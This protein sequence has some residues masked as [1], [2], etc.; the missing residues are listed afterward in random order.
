MSTTFLTRIQSST[1]KWYPIIKYAFVVIVFALIAFFYFYPAITDGREL[2]QPDVAGVS[3]NGS[4]VKEFEKIHP[5]ST[6]Y[7]TNSLFGG[8][9]MYQIAPSYPSVKIVDAMQDIYTLRGPLHLLGGYSWLLF[10]LMIGFF[11][12]LKSLKVSD[13]LSFFG[14]LFW[15]FSSYYLILIA[16]GHIWKLMV[17]AYIPPTIAGMVLIYRQKYLWGGITLTFFVALQLLANHLQM[18]YY[19]LFVMLSFFIVWLVQA[20]RLHQYKE[21][22]I[23]TFVALLSGIVG[24]AINSTNLYHTYQYSKQTMRGGSELSLSPE[25]SANSE[26]NTEG[27]SKGYITQW[28]YGVGETLS[29]LVPNIRGGAS[30]P[31]SNHSDILLNSNPQMAQ[32]VSQFSS[33]WG[34]QPF[35]AGPVYVGVFIFML[36]IMACF[37]VR[38]PIKWALLAMTLFSILLSWGK[39]FMPLTDFFIDYIPLYD[40]FRSVSSIL[41][42]A[43]FT[44]PTLAILGILELIKKPDVLKGNWIV[45]ICAFG[46]PSLL[47]VLMATVPSLFGTFLTEQ[48]AQFFGKNIIQ[49]QG[50]EL[51]RSSLI[52]ARQTLLVNDAKVALLII[53]FSLLALFLY[54]YNRISTMFFVVWIGIVSFVDLWHIDKRYLHDSMFVEP[55]QIASKTSIPSDIDKQIMSLAKP[56]DRVLNLTVDPFND[57]STSRWHLS[58][59]GYHAAKLQRYQ[60]LIDHQLSKRLNPQVLNMLNTRFIIVRDETT[61]KQKFEI[62]NDVYGPAWFVKKVDFV[63][64]ANEEMLALNHTSLNNVAVVDKRFESSDL[65]NLQPLT[66]SLPSIKLKT[67]EPNRITYKVSTTQSALAVFSEIYYPQGWHAA[68]MGQNSELPI[69]RA[70]YVLRGVLLPAGNYTLQFWFDPTSMHV[71][72]FIAKT[73]SVLLIVSI[74]FAVIY[75]I[76]YRR[77]KDRFKTLGD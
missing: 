13:L 52:D 56:A 75:P 49:N 25:S 26:V 50:Y 61:G 39:N 48:E 17:L 72:E 12:F 40:K 23:S 30:E 2:Y 57:A 37:I 65:K 68:I 73:A 28:S 55:S 32:Y 5:D 20:I 15:A 77:K 8:M 76:I 59:G 24:I 53:A 11:I 60:D 64:N 4:D 42:I 3:G 16:A 46:I 44:I 27:L 58:I 41:V 74:L 51:L 10:I 38:S 36:A 43:E 69:I 34:N 6:S 33:Y 47:V 21:F 18:T 31:L 63:N 19:F 71:T 67:F 29:L 70:D 66:D 7:W 1:W 22:L 45:W 62:N 35:T 54:I 14:S 9:P